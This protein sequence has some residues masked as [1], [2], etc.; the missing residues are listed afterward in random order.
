MSA[1]PNRIER[2]QGTAGSPVDAVL[3]FAAEYIAA[4]KAVRALLISDPRDCEEVTGYAEFDDR[5]ATALARLGITPARDILSLIAKARVLALPASLAGA[6]AD[7]L[8]SGLAADLL[9]FEDR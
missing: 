4:T 1:Y 5:R 7:P 6:H 3:R 2:G 9:S 8:A